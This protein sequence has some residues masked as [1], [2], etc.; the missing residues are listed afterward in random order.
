MLLPKELLVQDV[1]GVTSGPQGRE[2]LARAARPPTGLGHCWG[3]PSG[4]LR[5]RLGADAPAAL[6]AARSLLPDASAPRASRALSF[7]VGAGLAFLLALSAVA[8]AAVPVVR[9]KAGALTGV[10]DIHEAAGKVL[11]MG[12]KVVLLTH[13]AGVC[14]YDGMQYCDQPFQ[15]YPMEGRTGRGDT[16]SAAFLH[17]KSK[18]MSLPEA[19]EFAAGITSRKLQYPGPYRG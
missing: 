19:V 9:A 15:P 7:V 17:A 13:S 1:D 18:G 16:C 11:A 3:L 12:P 2:L 5:P 10:E 6:T 8:Q 14:V 4:G